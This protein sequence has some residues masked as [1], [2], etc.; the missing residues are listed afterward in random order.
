[1]SLE[2]AKNNIMKKVEVESQS[3]EEEASEHEI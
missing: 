2:D 3:E 1:M